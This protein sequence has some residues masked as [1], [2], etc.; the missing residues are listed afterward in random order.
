MCSVSI[1]ERE[2]SQINR[3]IAT[4]V[5]TTVADAVKTS[6]TLAIDAADN[7]DDAH[8]VET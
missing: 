8:N 7:H 6:G 5:S 4:I 2:A 1:S 3:I